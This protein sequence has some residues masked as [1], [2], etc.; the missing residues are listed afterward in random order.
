[1]TYSGG[2]FVRQQNTQT[3]YTDYSVAYDGVYGSGAFWT[4]QSGTGTVLQHPQQEITG[5]DKFTKESHEL[6]IASPATDRFRMILGGF[7]QR[8]SHWII[9][10]YQIQGFGKDSSGNELSVP[11][12]ANT[13]WLTDQMRIDRD[14]AVFGEFSYDLFA[15]LTVTGGIRFYQ[16]DNSL[17]GFFGFSENY[18]ALTGYNS[19][20]GAT[21]QNCLST[22]HY[23]GDPCV[24][25]DKTVQGSGETHKFNVTYK[26]DPWRL[27]YFTYS[28]GYRPGGINRNGN[29][30]AYGSDTLSNLE[31]G[32]KFGW[33][34]NRI[35]WN[36][37]LF[38]EDWNNVQFSFLGP[39][40]LTIIQNAGQANSKGIETDFSWQVNHSL[41]L[42][43]AGTYTDAKLTTPYC[44]D[45]TITC[46]NAVADA[47]S[48]TQ[49]PVTP[50]IKANATARYTFGLLGMNGHA[51][52]S[53]VYQDKNYPGLRTADNASLGSMPS[54]TTADFS[55]GLE[56][57][58]MALELFIKNAF[59][60]HG[61]I[62]RYTPCTIAICTAN[63]APLAPPALYIVP[64]QPRTIGLKLS[65]K[66]N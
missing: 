35:K 54:Y 14:K 37:A 43:A 5:T 24:N 56:K 2:Y 6:R 8:Q 33:L 42:T 17:K 64:V 66:F 16:Y 60:E 11:G 23:R 20:M 58:G 28:T 63:I 26:F 18:D 9:Q 7:T 62:T 46:T 25:L 52:G 51:Q 34:G 53:V 3:D 59:D 31:V 61:Q 55:F 13:I 45:Q 57:S 36:G 49:L 65:K 39:N 41:N 27:I 29:F 12:W 50:K 47:P 22:A 10:D 19:G 44:Q 21:G 15:G 4:D 48:G 38:N 1:V 40:S 30:G 32:W